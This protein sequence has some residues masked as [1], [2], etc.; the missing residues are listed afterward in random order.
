MQRPGQPTVNPSGVTRPFCRKP[1][2]QPWFFI[3]D[4]TQMETGNQEDSVTSEQRGSR[5]QAPSR[6]DADNG[7]I[8]RIPDEPVESTGNEFRRRAPGRKSSFSEDV[9][10]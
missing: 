8:H 10:L 3:Q 4:H 6:D 7:N 9:E 5:S 1:P 2:R